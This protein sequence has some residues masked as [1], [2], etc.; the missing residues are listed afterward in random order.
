MQK[1]FQTSFG[2]LKTKL[3]Q[4]IFNNTL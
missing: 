3:A 1:T 4:N 2:I